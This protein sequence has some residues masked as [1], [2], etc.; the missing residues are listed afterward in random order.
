MPAPAGSALLLLLLLPLCADT[1]AV[2]ADQAAG[3]AETYPWPLRC[4]LAPAVAA[5]AAELLQQHCCLQLE[6]TQS[7]N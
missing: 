1:A 6:R 5:I 2:S 4:G 7:N 3:A